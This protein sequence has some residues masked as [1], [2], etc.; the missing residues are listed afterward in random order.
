MLDDV[1][2]ERVCLTCGSIDL[3][4]SIDELA[5]LV[6]EG[7]ELDPFAPCLSAF[8]NRRRDKVKILHWDRNGFWL[9]Y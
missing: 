7:F 9:C 1:D 3:P 4:K 2:A 5:A 6:K 8:C